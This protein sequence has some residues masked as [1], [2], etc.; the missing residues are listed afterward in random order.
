MEE[1]DIY[2]FHQS[3]NL[4]DGNSDFEIGPY[5]VMTRGYT[6]V[7][8]ETKHTI[9]IFIVKVYLCNDTQF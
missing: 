3:V 6:M 5:I 1:R 7:V 2:F 9:S 8:V 4:K